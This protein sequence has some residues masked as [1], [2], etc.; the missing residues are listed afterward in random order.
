[1]RNRAKNDIKR[2]I[3]IGRNK[4]QKT[5]KKVLT[6]VEEVSI[7]VNVVARGASE[8]ERAERERSDP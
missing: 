2:A 5:F 7:I 8:S 1:M 6:K 4:N 3:I